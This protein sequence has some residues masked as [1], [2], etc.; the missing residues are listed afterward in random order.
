MGLRFRALTWAERGVGAGARDGPL[1][2]SASGEG[3]AG[4]GA[5][6]G[7]ERKREP[8]RG[9]GHV[10]REGMVS[11]CAAGPRGKEVGRQVGLPGLGWK[12]KE[13]GPRGKKRGEM[14]PGRTGL[15]HRFGFGFLFYFLPLLFFLKHHSN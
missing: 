8:G 7:A 3:R 11:G 2:S 6:A 12:K 1:G 4:V 13:S 14:R 15:V 5:G 9:N 10:G